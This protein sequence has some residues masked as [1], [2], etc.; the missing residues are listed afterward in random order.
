MY[1]LVRIICYII[2]EF[3]HTDFCYAI[4]GTVSSIVLLLYFIFQPYKLKYAVYNKVTIAMI[5]AIVVLIFCTVNVRM[6]HYKMYQAANL[7]IAL[8]GISSLVPQLYII[9]I[10]MKWI[11]IGKLILLLKLLIL[12]TDK[13][14]ISSEVSALI[15]REDRVQSLYSAVS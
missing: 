14:Q 11:G 10:A 2:Y 5:T 6:A 7:S 15:N 1:L 12:N 13:S 9:S 8:F 4:A 3:I